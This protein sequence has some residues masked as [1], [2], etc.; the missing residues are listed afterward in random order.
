[1]EQTIGRAIFLR[2]K[3]KNDGVRV[4]LKIVNSEGKEMLFKYID[5]SIEFL[6]KYNDVVRVSYQ[7]GKVIDIEV[8]HDMDVLGSVPTTDQL[9]QLKPHSYVNKR[10]FGCGL[11]LLIVYL[12]LYSL[13]LGFVVG[14]PG[15]SIS[16][17]QFTSDSGT[18]MM[19]RMVF[20]VLM[21][22]LLVIS[23]IEPQC[24]KMQNKQQ[25]V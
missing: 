11:G 21:P 9:R 16:F 19:I 10:M 14:S 2:T 22:S 6:P 15:G 5:E 8:V 3:Q 7:R 24:Q 18:N 20:T 13:Y 17:W 4:W 12:V 1:M 25:T 23:V